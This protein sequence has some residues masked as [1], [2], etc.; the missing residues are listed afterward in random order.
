MS[1]LRQRKPIEVIRHVS[2]TLKEKTGLAYTEGLGLA[3][4]LDLA[5]NDLTDSIEKVHAGL[6]EVE[7][8][9]SDE[10]STG[11]QRYEEAMK[12]LVS[13]RWIRSLLQPVNFRWIRRILDDC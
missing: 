4:A 12:V 11:Q 3:M 9:V 1:I 8:V 10:L 7:S 6:R 13:S 5:A 2:K